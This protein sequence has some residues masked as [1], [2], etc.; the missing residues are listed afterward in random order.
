MNTV[1]TGVS[2]GRMSVKDYDIVCTVIAQE[3][4]AAGVPDSLSGA[5]AYL[6]GNIYKRSSSH[7]NQPDIVVPNCPV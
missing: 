7:S 2:A 1:A 3:L 4:R 5:D 6:D